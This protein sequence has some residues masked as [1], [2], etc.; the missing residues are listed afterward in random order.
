MKHE[1]VL[2]EVF[3][4]LLPSAPPQEIEEARWRILERVRV[5][6]AAGR[7]VVTDAVALNHGHYHILLALENADCH[8]YAIALDVEALTEGATKFGPGTFFTSIRKLLMDGLIEE[9][10]RRP[11]LRVN[12][13]PRQY[14]RLTVSGRR[15]LAQES[16]RLAARLFHAQR[17]QPVRSI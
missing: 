11:D 2:D 17:Q 14:Y 12:D 3:G 5:N 13:E 9:T 4:R 1:S 16:E 7:E 15:V 8:A 10:H 6:I